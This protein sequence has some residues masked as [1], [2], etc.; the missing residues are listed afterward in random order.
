MPSWCYV[1]FFVVL[2]LAAIFA[3]LKSLRF[4]PKAMRRETREYL[5]EYHANKKPRR[6][7]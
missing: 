1:V 3:V 2:A 5:S 4:E 6:F 7:Y